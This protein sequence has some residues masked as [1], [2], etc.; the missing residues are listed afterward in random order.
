MGYRWGIFD[1]LHKNIHHTLLIMN[2]NYAHIYLILMEHK[3]KIQENNIII[4]KHIYANILNQYIK[5]NNVIRSFCINYNC[6]TLVDGLQG[7]R[8]VTR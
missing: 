8:Y 2:Q 1:K 6:L 4:D 5:N 7:L 3:K